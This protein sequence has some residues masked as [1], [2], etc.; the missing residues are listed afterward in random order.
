[1]NSDKNKL[2]KKNKSESDKKKENLKAAAKYSGMAFQMGT[3]IF[4]G[5]WGGKQLDRYFNIENHIITGIL[6][7]FSVIVAVYFAVKDLI[8]E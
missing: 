5:A 4:L 2:H 1:M 7:V 6:T 3:L 8:K